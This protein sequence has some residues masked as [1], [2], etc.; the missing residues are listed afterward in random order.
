MDAPARTKAASEFFNSVIV[1]EAFAQGAAAGMGADVL[2]A[3][4]A[5]ALA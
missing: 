4:E 3:V 2:Y 1:P 5:E